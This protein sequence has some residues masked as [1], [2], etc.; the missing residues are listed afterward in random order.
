M[1]YAVVNIGLTISSTETYKEINSSKVIVKL[2]SILL[3][4]H[5]GNLKKK[6]KKSK[7]RNN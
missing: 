3:L 7:N 6:V 5:L 4:T 1:V 2:S